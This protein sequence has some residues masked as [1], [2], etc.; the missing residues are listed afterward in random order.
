[1]RLVPLPKQASTPLPVISVKCCKD[2]YSKSC[3][4]CHFPTL[5]TFL[6]LIS[7]EVYTT[8]GSAAAAIVW[9]LKLLYSISLP[10]TSTLDVIVLC[11]VY[12][13]GLISCTVWYR[14]AET[15]A[16]VRHQEED[17]RTQKQTY[18]GNVSTIKWEGG[19][20]YI[21]YHVSQKI[22]PQGFLTFFPNGWEFLVQILHAYYT[23]L[24][25]L[26]Y[27]FLFNYLKLWLSYAILSG[28]VHIIC[29]M[30]TIGRNARVQ[31]FA[32]V[33]DSFV[34]RCLWQVIIDLLQCTF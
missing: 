29:S 34:D 23:F 21:N 30:S 15:A 3:C 1:M 20:G 27:K 14:A 5:D 28:P 9:H 6:S 17:Q 11:S 2:Y 22:L 8:F 33:I 16:R 7:D 12:R 13:T 10:F 32:K 4:C 26:D 18:C 25:M 19:C 24:S 31:M